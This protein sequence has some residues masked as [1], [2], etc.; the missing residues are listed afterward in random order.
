MTTERTSWRFTTF[1]SLT[2]TRTRDHISDFPTLVKGFLTSP[3]NKTVNE[4]RQLSLWS[5]TEF[6]QGR[7]ARANAAFIYFLVFDMDD[8]VA[9]FDSWRLFT[10]FHVLAHTSYSHK[11]QHHKYRII[12]PLQNPIPARDWS[13]ASQA[14]QDLWDT[15]VGRG[16]PDQAALHDRARAYFRYGIPSP[17]SDDML[18]SDPL[19][20]LQYHQTAWSMGTP[21]DL[22]YDHITEPEPRPRQPVKAR[23]HSNGKAA[24]SE[25]M[26]D[27]S[28]RLAVAHKVGATIQD[29]HA[30]YIKCPGCGR[31]SVHFSIDITIEGSFKWPTCN[32][33]NRCSWWGRF[34]DLI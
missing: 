33:L 21:L 34:E 26:L 17:P 1:P 22:T 4:K 14:A 32:H 25:V 23:A 9:P 19:N 28:F 12:L 15:I 11:P 27:P 10:D 2:D 7:R 24:M 18:A 30:R 6:K 31:D 16:T 8:G 29:N 13:R 5:P 3:G 20:P